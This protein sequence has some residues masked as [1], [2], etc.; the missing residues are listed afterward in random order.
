MKV[1]NQEAVRKEADR[2]FSSNLKKFKIRHYS[3]WNR[4][5][6]KILGGEALTRAL[7]HDDEVVGGM[8]IELHKLNEDIEQGYYHI[9]V[10]MDETGITPLPC[11]ICKGK[12]KIYT[13]S[14]RGFNQVHLGRTFFVPSY[15]IYYEECPLCHGSGYKP[16][17]TKGEEKLLKESRKIE[18]L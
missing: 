12:G 4:L 8:C 5:K 1:L 15:K 2:I 14:R 18:Q 6:W 7:R 17:L 13:E 3:F 10:V 11:D 9:E 16:A